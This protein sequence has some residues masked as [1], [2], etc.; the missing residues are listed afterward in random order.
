MN[1]ARKA[2][3]SV[4]I[5]EKVVVNTREVNVAVD[6]IDASAIGSSFAVHLVKDGQRIA[7]RF[8]FQPSD[9][10]PPAPP[11]QFAHFDFV[12]PIH[13]VADG[14]L[15]IEIEPKRSTAAEQRRPQRE[16]IGQAT[17]SVYLMLELD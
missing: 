13:V 16:Q 8:F 1:G 17:L 14:T 5:A 2:R 9:L 7:S 12:L 3:K 6:G 15:G 10:A 4:S 11:N